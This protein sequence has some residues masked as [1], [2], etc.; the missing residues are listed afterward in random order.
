M[1][2]FVA[3]RHPVSIL[4]TDFSNPDNLP[5]DL[6]ILNFLTE[7]HQKFNDLVRATYDAHTILY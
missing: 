7:V 6:L 1:A 3:L 5:E 2:T 4:V